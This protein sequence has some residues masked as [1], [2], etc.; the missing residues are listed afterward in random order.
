M[1]YGIGTDIVAVARMEGLLARYGEHF[2]RRI[3]G[4]SEWEEYTA[5]LMPGR[6]LAKRFAAKEALAKAVGTGLRHPVRLTH[7]AVGHDALGKPI[8]QFSSELEQFLT[9][10][11]IGPRHLSI[12]DEKEVV[13]AFVV[14]ESRGE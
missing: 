11:G 9:D 12:S 10:R 8:L 14:L 1:I 6:F 2:A 7:I 4:P 3:L 5:S 13:S